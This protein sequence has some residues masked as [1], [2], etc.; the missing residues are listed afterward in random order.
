M[1]MARVVDPEWLD[2]LLPDD[3]RAL[4]SRR[5]LALINRIMMQAGIMARL[6]RC[7]EGAAQPLRFLEIGSGDGGFMLSVARRLAQKMPDAEVLLLDRQDGVSVATMD[8]FAALGWRAQSVETD[9]FQFL[10]A[11]PER[12]DAISA[13]LFLHHFEPQA[14]T[15]MIA[16]IAART[17]L[18]AACE[19]RRDALGLAGSRML[20]ALGCN[21][22]TRHD[23]VVS[24]RAGFAGNELSQLW[25]S[26]GWTLSER[27]AGLFTHAFLAIRPAET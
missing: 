11:S 9:V 4:K 25:P 21:D 12:F 1:S 8:A 6:L 13:N 19:P 16:L 18:F 27:R 15:E 7:V 2:V 10:R 20:W 24:V 26:D 14:L 3:P 22:V 5:D 23:A 17:S